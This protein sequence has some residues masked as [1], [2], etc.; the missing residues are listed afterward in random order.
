MPCPPHAVR[1][2]LDGG[3]VR[4]VP[5]KVYGLEGGI[6]ADVVPLSDVVFHPVPWHPPAI[7]MIG[8]FKA[9]HGEPECDVTRTP[10][11]AK[12]VGR[13][14]GSVGVQHDGHVG[15]SAAHPFAHVGDVGMAHGITRVAHDQHGADVGQHI[16]MIAQGVPRPVMIGVRVRGVVVQAAT[17][18][19]PPSGTVHAPR[20]A[21]GCD[22]Q[23]Y[24]GYVGDACI[25][26][27]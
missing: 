13:A 18:V 4:L 22:G 9:V 3:P 1:P 25:H 15:P 23:V 17:V 5:R 19:H 2:G 21:H 20:I 14:Q 7:D 10:Q 12:G 11:P 27:Q 24:D 8:V 26:L 6:P 16:Q